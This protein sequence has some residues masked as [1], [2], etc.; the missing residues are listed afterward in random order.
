MNTWLGQGLMQEPRSDLWAASLF[1]LFQHTE[2]W[3]LCNQSFPITSRSICIHRVK[4]LR[5]YTKD[6]LLLLEVTYWLECRR[7]MFASEFRSIVTFA[8]YLMQPKISE[9][10]LCLLALADNFL[11]T[12]L[13]QLYSEHSAPLT[14]LSQAFNRSHSEFMWLL[15]CL[16]ETILEGLR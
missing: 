8:N 15:W 1:Y 2:W 11:A 7:K 6:L 9:K 12:S 16:H 4:S 3:P 10:I 14:M 5:C 13:W